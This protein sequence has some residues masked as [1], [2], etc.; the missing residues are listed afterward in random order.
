MSEQSS[1]IIGCFHVKI[2]KVRA[3]INESVGIFF[4]VHDHKVNVKEEG[5]SF[6]DA[7]YDGGTDRN[8]GNEYAVHNVKM[9]PVHGILDV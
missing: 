2:D 9:K 1:R 6:S 7:G 5:S 4:G 3:G 8:V